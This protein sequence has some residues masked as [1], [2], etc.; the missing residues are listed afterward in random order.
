[1]TS[2]VTKFD[3]SGKNVGGPK[4]KSSGNYFFSVKIELFFVYFS[5]EKYL[6]FRSVDRWVIDIHTKKKDHSMAI[7]ITMSI[8]NEYFEAFIQ[9][10]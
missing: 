5:Y 3:A 7:I 9:I 2:N 6:I 1:L 8:S 4:E 10:H